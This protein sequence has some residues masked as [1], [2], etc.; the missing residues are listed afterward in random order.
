MPALLCGLINNNFISF[1]VKSCIFSLHAK[2]FALRFSLYFLIVFHKTLFELAV[3]N[4]L[5]LELRTNGR[6]VLAFG[7]VPQTLKY[8]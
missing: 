2:M 5:F 8:E 3:A 6:L 1:T 4:L 7:R